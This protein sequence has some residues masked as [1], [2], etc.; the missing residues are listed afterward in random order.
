MSSVTSTVVMLKASEFRRR[1]DQGRFGRAEIAVPGL[2]QR[3][4]E[5]DVEAGFDDLV[6][7]AEHGAA[8]RHH[9]GVAGQS[10]KPRM[11]S[12]WTST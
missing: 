5:R 6:L 8:D 12:G 9:P 10:A 1:P 2:V 3:A 7:G 11:R 4:R